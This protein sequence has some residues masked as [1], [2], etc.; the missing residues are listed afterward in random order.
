MSKTLI[1]GVLAVFVVGGAIAYFAM[2]KGPAGE[3]S[4]NS[5]RTRETSSGSIADLMA[6]Q[7]DWKCAV[8]SHN[9]ASNS[10]GTVY[11]SNGEIRG[12][13]ESRIPQLDRTIESHMINM[14]G[15]VYVW[16]SVVPQGFKSKAALSGA[17]SAG[18]AGQGVDFNQSYQY[19]CEPWTRDASLFAL[20]QDVTFIGN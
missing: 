9:D 12:D 15:Y 19:S 13:F 17:S 5:E 8:A 6:R 20:P 16:S 4:T 2:P 11:V 7:G 1:I 10:S 3:G 14:G 18:T